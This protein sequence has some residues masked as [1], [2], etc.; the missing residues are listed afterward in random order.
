MNEIIHALINRVLVSDKKLNA[1]FKSVLGHVC[2]QRLIAL[3][4][5]KQSVCHIC[6]GNITM[7]LYA[8]L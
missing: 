3:L 6:S 4:N 5:K 8:A 1:T 7:Q 2:S